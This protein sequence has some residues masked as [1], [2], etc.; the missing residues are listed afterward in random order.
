MI[1]IFCLVLLAAF[2]GSQWHDC[3]QQMEC[4]TEKL[5]TTL[6]CIFE[7]SSVLS[8]IPARLAM[9]LNVP[10][11]RKFV[12]TADTA[13]KMLNIL[14]PKMIQLGGDGLLR[15]MM[16]NGIMGDD[17]IR[18]VADFIMAAG[19]TVIDFDHYCNFDVKSLLKII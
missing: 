15:K 9:K 2:I 18:I 14:V 4:Y 8:I 6:H 12:E 1:K 7:Y 13:L 10:A 3:K 17:I 11:W 16:D 5:A 19:D